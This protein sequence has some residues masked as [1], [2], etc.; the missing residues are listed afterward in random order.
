MTQKLIRQYDIQFVVT[1]PRLLASIAIHHIYQKLLIFELN[2]VWQYL[3]IF[4]NI[5][6]QEPSYLSQ[7]IITSKISSNIAIYSLVE[8][9]L[10]S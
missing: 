1:K 5:R 2:D 10:N 6:Q 9:E 4:G 8:T 7:K 3:M